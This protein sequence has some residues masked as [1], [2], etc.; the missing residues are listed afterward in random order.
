MRR[1]M[2][3]LRDRGEESIQRYKM[4]EKLVTIGDDYWIENEAGERVFYV[5]GKALRIRD[6]LIL[7]DVQGNEVYKLKEKLLR[8][9]DTMEIEDRDGKTVATIKKA[10]IS[11]LRDRFK[12]EV[13]NGPEL[14][15]QGNILDHEYEIKEG[16]EK[17]A[18]ISK[19]WFRI[20][21]TYGVEVSPGQ[22]AALILAITAAL[23]QMVHD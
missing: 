3:G 10:L 14:D 20:R 17:V 15:I 6:T 23:D 22:D 19:K 8:I 1:I 4:H 7:K 18:E 13:S 9:K 5:D 12:V 21:D 16:R 11:P 2:G